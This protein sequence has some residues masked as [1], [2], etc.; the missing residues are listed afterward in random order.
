VAYSTGWGADGTWSAF[1]YLGT[2]EGQMRWTGIVLVS[3]EA[4]DF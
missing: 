2:Q 4:K 3:P 1:L